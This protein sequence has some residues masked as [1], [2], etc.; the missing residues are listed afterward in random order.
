MKGFFTKMV[1]G[2]IGFVA[3]TVTINILDRIIENVTGQD[4][5]HT[6]SGLIPKKK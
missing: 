6:V 4:I 5:A 2:A 3:G 1:Y